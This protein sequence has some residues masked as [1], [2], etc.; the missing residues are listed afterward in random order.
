MSLLAFQHRKTTSVARVPGLAALFDQLSDPF[1]AEAFGQMMFSEKAVMSKLN[2][3]SG[4]RAT[5]HQASILAEIKTRSE[6]KIYTE[7][8]IPPF[9]QIYFPVVNP[10]KTRVVGSVTATLGFEEI[11]RN[12][13][14]ANSDLV[15]I[16]FENSC[17]QV[18]T[19]R[20]KS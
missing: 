13:V 6:N 20:V 1:L 12:A 11:L 18:L 3:A 15:E 4:G 14:P 5:S 16:V 10:S 17:G 7:E 2:I 8:E 19:Y 9:V